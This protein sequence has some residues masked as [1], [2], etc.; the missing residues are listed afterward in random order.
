MS[1]WMK[2]AATRLAL[3]A[4]FAVA[5]PAKGQQAGS[6][7]RPAP[8]R[9]PVT[10]A[11]VDELP[12]A[13][14]PFALLRRTEAEGGDVI[15]LPAAASPDLLSEAVRALL[16]VRRHQ[17]DHAAQ[18]GTLRVTAR[19]SRPP[20]LPWAARVLGDVRRTAPQSVAGV[21]TARSVV[22]WLPP[23]RPR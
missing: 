4:L 19:T 9:I 8:T 1:H 10:V 6:P 13:Q 11:M 23:Q 15:L 7:G 3:L 5:V 22:I 21:G 12:A 14:A 17:G 20:A 16:T 18:G 2:A